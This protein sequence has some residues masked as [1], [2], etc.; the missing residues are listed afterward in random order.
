MCSSNGGDRPSQQIGGFPSEDEA[1]QWIA[2]NSAGWFRERLEEFPF[3]CAAPMR[4]PTIA[5]LKGRGREGL[6]AACLHSAPFTFAVLW[7]EVASPMP[8]ASDKLGENK[9]GREK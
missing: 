3:G 2:E 9:A 7:L 5:H 8:A 1:Q 4:P 6:F